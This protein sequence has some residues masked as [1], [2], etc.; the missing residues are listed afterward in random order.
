MQIKEEVISI[1]KIMDLLKRNPPI[2]ESMWRDSLN[3]TRKIEM[4]RKQEYSALVRLAIIRKL[5]CVK[6][7]QR[8]GDIEILIIAFETVDQWSYSGEQS[9]LCSKIKCINT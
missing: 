3:Y 8:F 2:V 5:E 6:C 9:A 1:T 4:E 7:I